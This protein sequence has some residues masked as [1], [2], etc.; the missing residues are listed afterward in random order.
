MTSK[1][2]YPELDE[3]TIKNLEIVRRLALQHP[4]YFLEGPYSADTERRITEWFL[5]TKRAIAE[6]KTE[7]GAEDDK[8]DP[9]DML[10]SESKTLFQQ[11]KGVKFTPEETSEQMSYFRTAT[12]LLEKLVSLQERS[13]GLKEIGDFQRTIMTIMETVL[14]PTQRTEVMER[15]KVSFSTSSDKNDNE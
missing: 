5:T 8:R 11:L 2:F 12:S 3:A 14:T 10:Y 15:L 7:T 4:S 1:F 13:L 6:T 9:W